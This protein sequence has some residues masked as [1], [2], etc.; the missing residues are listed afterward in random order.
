M[1]APREKTGPVQVAWGWTKTRLAASPLMSASTRA[2]EQ[3]DGA[4]FV[5]FLWLLAQQR[6][7]SAW[8]NGGALAAER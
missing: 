5:F 8:M 3:A 7:L 4:V 6:A 2:L 1:Q